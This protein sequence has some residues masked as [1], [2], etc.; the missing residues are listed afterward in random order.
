MKPAPI[1]P[2]DSFRRSDRAGGT[3]IPFSPGRAR[4][5]LEDS[6]R[7][8]D[9]G[10][11]TFV[12]GVDIVADSTSGQGQS[13]AA[14]KGHPGP[15]EGEAVGRG[16]ADAE[17]IVDAILRAI[18][19]TDPEE[20]KESDGRHISAM[21]KHQLPQL[22]LPGFGDVNSDDCGEFCL[23]ATRFCTRCGKTH[24]FKHNCLTYD[25]P[26]HAPYAVRRR[27]ASGGPDGTG[28]APK[29]KSLLLRLYKARGEQNHY[30]HHIFIS[31]PEDFFFESEQPLERGKQVIREI[32]DELGLQGLVGYHPVRG[33]DEDR[34]ADDRGLWQ[35]ILFHRMDW[36]DVKDRLKYSPHFHIIAVAPH[37][38]VSVTEEVEARTGWV[39]HRRADDET[40]VSIP[41]DDAMTRAVTYL[42]SHC[43]VYE[44]DDQ[45][46]LAAWMKG[47]DIPTTQV[48]EQVAETI[49]ASVYQSAEKVLGL[50]QPSLE[51]SHDQTVRVEQSDPDEV[52][53]SGA[54][55]VTS[56]PGPGGAVGTNYAAV[57]LP[58]EEGPDDWGDPSGF[59][60]WGSSSS[61]STASSS[62]T[63]SAS[64]SARKISSAEE[65][66]A[67]GPEC[68]GRLRH[69]SKAGIYILDDEWRRKATFDREL[70]RLYRDY[71]S[72]MQSRGL[73]PQEG[74]PELPEETDG[75]PPPD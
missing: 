23:P 12:P 26:L 59:E 57:S 53:E 33:E 19:P 37:V 9:V 25:C 48:F 24:E 41:D 50:Q 54:V 21:R 65:I 17:A 58:N 13:S 11:G 18:H 71:V 34:E 38:D 72:Y 4:E 49:R 56:N 40:N 70:D 74:K 45:R 32:M 52:A 8:R 43:G 60:N 31:P 66:D 39:I 5:R 14:R 35:E 36:D 42:L 51:C 44:T 55:T 15:P 62:R 30:F 69:I 20:L 46:R 27:A 2:E 68:G 64:S 3:F 47:P 73:D 7:G 63:S 28:I 75:P 16:E 6:F 10:G 67:S 22:D 29:L 1:F 61:G